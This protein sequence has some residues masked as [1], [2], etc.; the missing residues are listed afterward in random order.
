MFK[1]WKRKVF[2]IGRNKTGTTSLRAAMK[3]LGYKVGRQARAE[4]F[5]EDWG[6]RD[7]RQIIKY[8][9][10]ANFFQ[11]IP[12]SLDQTFQAVDEAYPGSRF[13]LTIR[14]DPL[15]W[16]ESLTRFHT[17]LVGK[18]RLPT[19]EDLKEFPYRYPGWLWRSQE[20]IYGV[21]ETTL[22]DRD[23]YMAHYEKHLESVQGYFRGREQDLLVLNL[24]QADAMDCLCRFLSI[25]ARGLEMPHL[26][27]S[28]RDV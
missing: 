16:Y 27:K 18:G 13:I 28:G 19:P 8:C 17:Q 22:Y 11:D 10:K 20:L 14:D 5:L 9:R 26:N 4:L 6:R 1:F 7:F 23:L 3:L 2:C 15:Q 12:F 25:E 21:D 24:S